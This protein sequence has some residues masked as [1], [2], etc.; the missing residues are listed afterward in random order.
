MNEQLSLVPVPSPARRRPS[1]APVSDAP[2]AEVD[3]VATVL[4][5]TPLPHLDRPFEYLVPLELAG[6][7]CPG[8]RVK[9]RF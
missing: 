9:V 1:T 7:A 2:L 8:A 4:V 6:T 5:D 3:P